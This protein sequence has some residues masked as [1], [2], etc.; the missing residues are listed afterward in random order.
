MVSVEPP[1]QPLSGEQFSLRFAS[2]EDNARFD[3][4]ASGVWGGRFERT[5]LDLYGFSTPMLLRIALPQPPLFMPAV[6]VRGPSR[7]AT[8]SEIQ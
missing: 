4:A 3:I 2:L 5:M 6:N 1:L 7:P 8:S